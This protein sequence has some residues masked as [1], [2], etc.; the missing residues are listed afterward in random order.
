MATT[1]KTKKS[2]TK[3]NLTATERKQIRQK[4]QSTAALLVRLRD[5]DR[6]NNATKGV[7][8]K[9]HKCVLD[10]VSY[11]GQLNYLE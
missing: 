5:N 7:I 1:K 3:R 8:K 10:A 6:I 4:L 11:S 2:A 9:M